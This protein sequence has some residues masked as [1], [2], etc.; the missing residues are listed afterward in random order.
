MKE[1]MTPVKLNKRQMV[2]RKYV[3]GRNIANLRHDYAGVPK[4]DIPQE[5][6][7]EIQVLLDELKQIREVLGNDWFCW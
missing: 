1:K 7:D 3:L 5:S 6:L 4:E 2:A